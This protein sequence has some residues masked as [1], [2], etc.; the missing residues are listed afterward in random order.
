MFGF[1]KMGWPAYAALGA[2]LMFI[3]AQAPLSKGAAAADVAAVVTDLRVGEH[4]TK[5]R[6]VFDLT[7]PVSFDVFT[8]ADPYRVVIDMP[9]IGWRLPARP[10]PKDKGLLSSLRYGLFRPGTTR[11]VLDTNGPVKVSQAMLLR[12]SKERG[13]RV[14]VDLNKTTRRAFLQN[15]K[16]KQVQS[17][18]PPPRKPEPKKK[19]PHVIV[20]D[21]GHGGKDPGTIGVSGVYEKNITLS[22][23]QE[24]KRQLEATGRY[25][26]ILTRNRDKAIALRK[27]VS[28]ARKVKAA[29]FISLHADS[30]KDRR[31]RGAAVYTLSE[32]A[33]DREAALLARKENQADI[34]AGV[35]LRDEPS[36]VANILIDLTQR[37]T[38]NQSSFFAEI[39]VKEIKKEVRLLRRTHRFAGFA[40]L[41]APDIPSVLVEL[42]YLSNRQ[43][44]K[45]LRN[46]RYRANMAQ[47]MVKAIDRYF[48]SVEE[49]RQL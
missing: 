33:S 34:I 32:Q 3:C 19:T 7:R 36:E 15:R 41:K 12:P 23:A 5:T 20:L 4:A 11:V 39:M 28:A 35:D 2:V 30:I 31:V 38:M 29:L 46:K 27:R 22:M 40:V 48:A 44:E 47:A 6:V 10:L 43:D 8:L 49:A 17:A 42:G 24:L 16:H 14:V 25:K 13:Y 26:V 21:P 37:E 18:A 9:Q 45:A 1:K